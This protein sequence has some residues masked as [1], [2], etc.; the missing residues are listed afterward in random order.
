MKY[1]Y[2]KVDRVSEAFTIYMLVTKIILHE[3]MFFQVCQINIIYYRIQIYFSSV[4]NVLQ[5]KRGLRV[6]VFYVVQTL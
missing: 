6:I 3:K 5:T 4:L 2:K 1:R